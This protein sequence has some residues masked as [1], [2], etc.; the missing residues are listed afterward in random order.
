[1]F[2]H[3]NNRQTIILRSV[4][5]LRELDVG[6]TKT[7]TPRD[8]IVERIKMLYLPAG[9][10]G[11]VPGIVELLPAIDWTVALNPGL[12]PIKSEVKV[13]N[14]KLPVDCTA[15]GIADPLCSSNLLDKG[16]G[17]SYTYTQ[18]IGKTH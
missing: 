18:K 4:S 8:N 11:N 15:A 17:P 16:C 13:T 5:E 14:M 3:L 7:V 10:V 6:P 12:V 9:R 1:M 2:K